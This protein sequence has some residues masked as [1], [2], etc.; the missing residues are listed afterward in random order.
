MA[1]FLINRTAQAYKSQF[2]TE[3]IVPPNFAP[4]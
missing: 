4:I 2:L 3:I 1:Q